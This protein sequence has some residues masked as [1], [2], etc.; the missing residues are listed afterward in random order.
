M[1]VRNSVVDYNELRNSHTRG[2][3]VMKAHTPITMYAAAFPRTVPGLID[4]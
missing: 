1:L 2:H 3:T 4:F